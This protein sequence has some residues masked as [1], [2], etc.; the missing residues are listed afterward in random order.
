MATRSSAGLSA[1]AAG[2]PTVVSVVMVA[3]ASI[4]ARTTRRAPGRPSGP[5]RAATCREYLRR[6]RQG[7]APR[8]AAGSAVECVVVSKLTPDAVSD[9]ERASID[10]LVRSEPALAA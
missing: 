7:R 1:A 6:L 5:R 4:A 2:E 9:A 10:A 3:R 8:R